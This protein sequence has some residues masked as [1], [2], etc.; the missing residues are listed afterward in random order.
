[1]EVMLHHA[2]GGS[3]QGTPIA[4]AREAPRYQESEAPWAE[5][6]VSPTRT[7]PARLYSCRSPLV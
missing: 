1:M 4:R 2:H 6:C 5:G 3:L 7:M